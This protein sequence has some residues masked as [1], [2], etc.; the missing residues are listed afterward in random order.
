M[1]R[2]DVVLLDGVIG[3]DSAP[4]EIAQ[5]I[6]AAVTDACTPLGVVESARYGDQAVYAC[7]W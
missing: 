4:N 2:P 5:A 7:Q 1:V 3:C 6:E